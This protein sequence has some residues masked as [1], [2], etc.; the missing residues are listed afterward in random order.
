[1]DFFSNLLTG[2]SVASTPIN[3]VYCFIGAFVGTLVGVLP[4]IGP[5]G[6][7]AIL[8]PVTFGLPP[9]TAIIMLAGIFYGAMY[10]GSTTSILVNIPGESASV[11][12]CLDGYQMARNGRAGAALG[13]SAFGSFIAGTLGVIG[14]QAI[15]LPMVSVALRFGPPEY[16]SLMILALVVLTYLAQQSIPKAMMMAAVGVVLGTIGLDAMTGKPRFTFGIP[17]FFDGVGLVPLAMGIFGISEVFINLEQSV[18]REVY[19]TKLKNLLPT[20]QDW[21]DS[22]WAILRGTVIGFLIGVLPGLG[23]SVAS[24]VS[25]A[26]EKRLSKT[27]EKFGQGIIQGVAGPESANNGAATGHMVPLLTMG[28]PTSAGVAMLLG[29]LMIHGITPGPMLVK[30][31]PDVFWGVIASMYIG[32]I[33]LLIINLP[34]IGLWVRLLR[35]PYFILFPMI[36]LLCLI[37]SYSL[38]G[39]TI[40][41]FLML[42]FGVLG[43]LMR[44]F[45]YEGAPLL[46]AFV[47]TPIM[48]NALRQSL[49]LSGGNFNIFLLR[50]ISS[51]CLIIAALLLVTSV[52]PI[53]RKKGERDQPN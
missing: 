9:V 27:P 53:F 5:V 42:L 16:F 21:M 44:K 37:G 40:D 49:I 30:Q 12:T 38:N 23:C 46:L 2:L 52:F 22:K 10:G 33:M 7:M 20:F 25:Y 29:A 14:L 8:L 6:A 41:V 18:K 15:A 1:M 31:H 50:P 51:G 36:L 34:M 45:E 17:E 47:L 4:G 19:E 24:F 39:S 13:I 48:E 11:V 28:I 3:L 32:N 43:Y 26:V 35:V